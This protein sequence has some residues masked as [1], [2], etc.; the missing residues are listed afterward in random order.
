MG[1]LAPWLALLPFLTLCRPAIFGL[2]SLERRST[3]SG[4]LPTSI[5]SQTNKSL[6]A[7]LAQDQTVGADLEEFEYDIPNTSR[8]VSIVID[9]SEHL[10]H[11]SFHMVIKNTLSRLHLHI[12]THGDGPIWPVDNP[13]QVIWNGC[14]STTEVYRK[15]DGTPWL[16]Y[17]I[18]KET[19]IGLRVILDNERLYF[20]AGYSIADSNQ[21]IYGQGT[22]DEVNST[23]GAAAMSRKTEK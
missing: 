16:T 5:V 11:V 8:Y 1:L 23:A 21:R 18:L 2:A 3:V 12:A 14:N 13:Y 9:I 20:L 7:N 19:F 22:I 17:G 15:L 6:V 4:S 10:D